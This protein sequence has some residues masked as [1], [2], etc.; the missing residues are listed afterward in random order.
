M[1]KKPHKI[2]LFTFC[3]TCAL[4]GEILYMMYTQPLYS[5]DGDIQL[6]ATYMQTSSSEQQTAQ[7]QVM[8]PPC[9][10]FKYK[11]T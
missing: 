7:F 1:A 8:G 9:F 10:N 11:E 3:L 4:G 2:Q 6:V 5:S